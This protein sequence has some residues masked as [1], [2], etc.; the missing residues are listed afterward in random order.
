MNVPVLSEAMIELFWSKAEP[1]PNSGCLLWTGAIVPTTGYGAFSA[2]RGAGLSKKNRMISTHVLAYTLARGP[3]PPGHEL[4]HLCRVR[5][6]M[7]PGHLDPVT[8]KV[9]VERSPIHNGSKTHCPRGHS[10]GDAIR[11]A[12]GSRMCRECNRATC[13]ARW[14]RRSAR[15]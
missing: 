6:C 3:I 9:N 13:A 15:A 2:R 12:N 11:R 14:R 5:C 8:R 7:E 1:E 4:D 10:Y